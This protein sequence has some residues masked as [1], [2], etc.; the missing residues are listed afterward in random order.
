MSF[1]FWPHSMSV[2]VMRLRSRMQMPSWTRRWST[3]VI[4]CSGRTRCTSFTSSGASFSMWSKSSRVS[5]SER[6]SCA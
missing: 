4:F 2:W 5:C 1:S 3:S 6:N